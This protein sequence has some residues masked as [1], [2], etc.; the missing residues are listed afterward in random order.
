[1]QNETLGGSAPAAARGAI[2]HDVRLCVACLHENRTGEQSCEACGTS[3]FLILCPVCEAA[4][5]ARALSCHSCGAALGAEPGER[6]AAAPPPSEAGPERTEAGDEPETTTAPAA[7]RMSLVRTEARD[8]RAPAP[9]AIG[10]DRGHFALMLAAVVVT[11]AG[12]T[13]YFSARTATADR[14]PQGKVVEVAP[15]KPVEAPARVPPNPSV[16]HTQPADAGKTAPSA[17]VARAA[18]L[19]AA[20]VKPVETPRRVAPPRTEP[21]A[22]IPASG[23]SASVGSAPNADPA[24]RHVTH[25]RPADASPA[26]PSAAV[27]RVAPEAGQKSEAGCGEAIAA[28]GLCNNSARNG[29]K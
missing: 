20:P 9:P 14:A 19:E 4:N 28:L 6:P 15:V 13:Y 23:A 8:H 25:T 1:M 7:G 5:G 10:M 24:Y 2:A 29:G 26:A 11:T 3:L 17:P 18:V 16:T 27:A 12:V 21:K 22:V